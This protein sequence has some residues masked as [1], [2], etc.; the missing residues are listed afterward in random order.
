[1][2]KQKET[3]VIVTSEKQVG[4]IKVNGRFFLQAMLGLGYDFYTATYELIDNAK[5]ADANCVTI[6]Y[7]KEN[8]VLTI[9]DN[10]KGMSKSELYEAMNLGTLKDNYE[11]NSVGYFGVGLK[12]G[13]LNMF[14][15][16]TET[17][18]KR[19]IKKYNEIIENNIV[20]IHTQNGD[21]RVSI[22]WAPW[23]DVFNFVEEEPKRKEKGTTITIHNVK[24]FYPSVLKKNLGVIYYNSLRN[25]NFQIYVVTTDKE[26]GNNKIIPNDPLY[27]HEKNIQIN[28]SEA[29]VCDEKIK[30]TAV[31]LEDHFEKISW[32]SDN[33]NYS[34]QK[35]GVYINYGGRYIEYGGTFGVAPHQDPWHNKTRI[36]LDVTKYLT[37]VFGIKCNKTNGISSLDNPLLDDL[38][39]K[40]KDLINWGTN[41][42]K[43]GSNKPSEEDVNSLNDLSKKVNKSAVNA[44]FKKP[45][46]EQDKK[47]KVIV[48]PFLANTNKEKK[49][50]TSKIPVIKEK[51][52][53]DFKI[54][55]LGVYDLCWDFHIYNG[56]FIITINSSSPFYIDIFQKMNEENQYNMIKFIACMAYAQYESF[57]DDYNEKSKMFWTT[58]WADFTRR[59]NQI[60]YS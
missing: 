22:S 25:D 42:R 56:K 33:K 1:M 49:E 3:D 44:G 39:R 6:F 31:V 12:G 35:G 58:F 57:K 38:R 54:E 34:Y 26:D 13:I 17:L 55:D 59:L 36:E 7:D 21:E 24:N 40:I 4:E 50:E 8:S 60:L 19:D 20:Y 14:E 41:I 47:E 9:Y 52:L 53:Y 43:R 48:G 18:R 32:D 15:R 45:I 28:Y 46:L 23:K 51:K 5:D 30:L 10:G 16:P 27:R 2:K 29:T 37:D 11:D